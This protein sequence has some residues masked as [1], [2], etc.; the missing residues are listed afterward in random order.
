MARLSA[1]D[2]HAYRFLIRRREA[3]LQLTAAQASALARYES[4]P[5]PE[6]ASERPPPSKKPR[7]P[8]PT[9]QPERVVSLSGAKRCGGFEDLPSKKEQKLALEAKMERRR[10]AAAAAP[11]KDVAQTQ[12]P[13]AAPSVAAKPDPILV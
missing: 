13:R 4:F 3:G 11:R 5:P 10:A 1:Q 9:P 7:P 8:G 12:R 6:S 2:E